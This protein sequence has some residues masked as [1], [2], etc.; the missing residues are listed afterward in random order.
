[1]SPFHKIDHKIRLVGVY[2]AFVSSTP[3]YFPLYEAY[4]LSSSV[5]DTSTS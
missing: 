5:E 2:H 4:S 1:M 3:T